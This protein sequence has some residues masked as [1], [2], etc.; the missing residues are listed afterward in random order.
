MYHPIMFIER[1]N[2]MKLI[3]AP[4]SYFLELLGVTHKSKTLF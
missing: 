1:D 3:P 4:F 2:K